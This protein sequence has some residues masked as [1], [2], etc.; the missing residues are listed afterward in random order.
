MLRK[1]V[2]ASVVD[3]VPEGAA[4]EVGKGETVGAMVGTV[5]AIAAPSVSIGPNDGAVVDDGSKDFA[6][7]VATTVEM[8]MKGPSKATAKKHNKPYQEQAPSGVTTAGFLMSSSFSSS[9]S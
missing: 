4:E 9:P 5:S 8:R 3:A 1:I 7:V 6:E 2:G